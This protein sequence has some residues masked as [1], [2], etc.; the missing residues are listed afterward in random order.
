MRQMI[1]T[2]LLFSLASTCG[3]GIVLGKCI[4]IYTGSFWCHAIFQMGFSFLSS[5]FVSHFIIQNYVKIL[6][7]LK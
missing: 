3:I 7:D 2:V 6:W 1:I 5:L 4:E